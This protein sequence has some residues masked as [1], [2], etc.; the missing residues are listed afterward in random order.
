MN[1]SFEDDL[2]GITLWPLE[3]SETVVFSTI[4]WYSMFMKGQEGEWEEV[5]QLNLKC[6]YQVI[7]KSIKKDYFCL[8][9]DPASPIV[10]PPQLPSLQPKLYYHMPLVTLGLPKPEDCQTF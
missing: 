1:N 7:S 3:N 9:L 10:S 4:V 6:N 8:L 5:D 2:L